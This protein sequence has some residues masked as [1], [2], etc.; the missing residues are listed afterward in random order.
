MRTGVAAFFFLRRRPFAGRS[1]A[2]T[3]EVTAVVRAVRT[4][5][6]RGVTSHSGTGS[7]S[8]ERPVKSYSAVWGPGTV[9]TVG[10]AT[11]ST[12]WAE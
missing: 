9:G 12:V 8:K 2:P 3:D 11:V 6:G 5:R 1:S 10:A 4:G 7:P